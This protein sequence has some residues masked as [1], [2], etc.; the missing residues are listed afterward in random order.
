M[1]SVYEF[2]RN[3]AFDARNFFDQGSIPQFQRNQFGVAR[4]GPDP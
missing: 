3:S 4:R 1:A 2:L